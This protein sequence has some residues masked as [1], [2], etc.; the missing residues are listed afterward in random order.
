MCKN[1]T[2][3]LVKQCAEENERGM[4][5]RLFLYL[6]DNDDT[7]VGLEDIFDRKTVRERHRVQSL[8]QFSDIEDWTLRN[9]CADEYRSSED[10]GLTAL[11]KSIQTYSEDD[12]QFQPKKL[13]HS[14]GANTVIADLLL[15]CLYTK[16]TY[17]WLRPRCVIKPGPRPAGLSH[18]LRTPPESSCSGLHRTIY[19]LPWLQLVNVY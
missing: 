8:S 14:V 4:K 19:R 18:R 16:C 9:K 10:S 1:G 5:F 6:T 11:S 7:D 2:I 15:S 3:R 13:G 17:S 12:K